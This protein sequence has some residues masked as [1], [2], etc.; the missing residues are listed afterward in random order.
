MKK[1]ISLFVLIMIVLCMANDT[2][3]AMQCK[4]VLSPEDT[5]EVTTNDEFKVDVKVSEIFSDRGL[6]AF[7][8]ILDYDK[9]SLKLEKMEGVGDYSAPAYNEK[10]GKIL[11]ERNPT[12]HNATMF[13]L[14][15][16]VL[17][18]D[19]V[20]VTM[21]DITVSD[22]TGLGKVETQ[23]YTPQIKAEVTPTPTITPAPTE[24]PGN[25]NQ[26]GTNQGGSDQKPSDTTIK[27]D[28]KLPQTGLNSFKIPGI[29]LGVVVILGV[30]YKKYKHMNM[31]L[32]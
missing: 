26:G 6:V 10:N 30:S 2:I 8:A 3:A 27:K 28:D 31:I 16:K 4:I 18:T 12:N 1:I 25:N 32:R 22:G 19:N 29:I 9:N 20:K 17:K 24:K 11:I 21:K 13:T 14:T 15:F 23:T 5:S 7:G